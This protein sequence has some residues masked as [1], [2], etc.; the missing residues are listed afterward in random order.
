MCRLEGNR[1]WLQVGV[2]G[3]HSTVTAMEGDPWAG[4]IWGLRDKKET[5]RGCFLPITHILHASS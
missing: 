5:W 3:W 4:D 1:K 2:S